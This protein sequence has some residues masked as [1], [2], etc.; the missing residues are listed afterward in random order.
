MT[1]AEGKTKYT[2]FLESKALTVPAM[3]RGIDHDDVSA[4][5]FDFQQAIVRWAVRKAALLS[6]PTQ[7][8]ARR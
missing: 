2:A 7:G 3:G 1:L 6:S 5:L 8:L 4:T